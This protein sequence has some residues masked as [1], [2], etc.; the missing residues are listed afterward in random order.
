MQKLD[1][2]YVK[3]ARENSEGDFILHA[4]PFEDG[5]HSADDTACI[6]FIK[7]T[8]TNNTYYFPLGHPDSSPLTNVRQMFI[9][10]WQCPNR[11]W[12]LDKKTFSHLTQFPSCDVDDANLCGFLNKNEILDLADYDTPA[13]NFIRRNSKGFKKINII[14]P[15]MKHAE[16]FEELADDIKKMIKNFETDE[17]YRKFNDIIIT[18]LGD[19]ERSGIYVDSKKFEEHFKSSPNKNGLVFSRYNVYT[20][21]GRPSNSYNSINYAALNHTDGSRECFVSRFGDDGRMVLIDYTAFHPRIICELT[22]YPIPTDVNIYEYLAKLYYQK[23]DVDETDIDNAKKLTFRQFYDG[24]EEKYAHIKYLANLRD[25]ID[26]QWNF[27]NEHGYVLTPYFKRKITS[28][29]ILNANP[30]K[31][32]N[33]ILQAAEGEVSIPRVKAV[34]DYLRDKNTKAILYTYDAVLYDFH[35]DD[36]IETLNEIRNIMSI[37]GTFPMKTYIGKSYADVKLVTI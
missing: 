26:Y 8:K 1:T 22:N 27:F 2:N 17:G 20:S 18:T 19:V 5:V 11:K 37:N 33:Y 32:F 9:E 30:T 34:M 14:I 25:Y 29:H 10:L 28:K 7:N 31:V 12:T 13:H 24:V 16:A 21:T 3:F 35:K 23:K 15:L 6:L 36:E 4:V